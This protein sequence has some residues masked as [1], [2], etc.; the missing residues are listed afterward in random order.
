MGLFRRHDERDKRLE[1]VAE[2]LT[3][4]DRRLADAQTENNSLQ[5]RLAAI[6]HRPLPAPGAS[7]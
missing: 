7:A 1:A 5:L 2:Q 4:L 6:E 3:D